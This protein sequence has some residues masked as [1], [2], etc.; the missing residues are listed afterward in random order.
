MEISFKISPEQDTY[1]QRFTYFDS[2]LF[3]VSIP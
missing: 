3:Q 1:F 2:E